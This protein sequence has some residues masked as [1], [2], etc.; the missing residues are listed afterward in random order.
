MANETRRYRP[1]LLLP[2]M[3]NCVPARLGPETKYGLGVIIR[4]T[5]RGLSYGPSG[6]FPG[7]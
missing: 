2:E 1:N 6:F 7:Y 5:T 4:R 3:L